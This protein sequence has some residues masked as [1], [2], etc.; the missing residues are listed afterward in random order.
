[1]TRSRS[2]NCAKTEPSKLKRLLE[3]LISHSL[4][5]GGRLLCVLAA[6][7]LLIGQADSA[8]AQPRPTLIWLVR[9]LPPLTIFEGPKKGQGVIDQLLPL[10]IAGMPQY[11]HSVL[12]VNR[13][14]GLQML[15][16]PSLTCDAALNRS[17][18][19]ERWIT[20]SIPV[21]QAMNNGLAVRRIDREMLTPFIT[22]GEVDLAALLASGREKLGIIAER[23]YGEYLDGLLKQAPANAL[24]LHYGNDAL[25][26]LLQMQRLGRLRLLLGYAPEIRYQA[27]L[28]GIAKDELQFYPIR[29]AEKYLSGYIGCT[30]T[31]QGRQAITEINQVLRTLPHERLNQAYAAW[32][33]PQSRDRY[34]EETGAFFQQQAGHR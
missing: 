14:R 1:M 29:G 22:D 2:H 27:E 3:R 10:L 31:A 13:A 33:D 9:D 28:Q 19:R 12:R 16:E 26:S 25:G 20:F 11:Q 23:N 18:E 5:H 15:H 7:S 4:S 32:L 34:L 8:Q 24:T 17:E 30:N 21:F 6:V